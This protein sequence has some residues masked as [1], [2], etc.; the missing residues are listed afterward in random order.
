MRLLECLS[1]ILAVLA[2]V[3]AIDGLA[4]AQDGPPMA[5]HRARYAPALG[6]RQASA[7]PA[8]PD[9]VMTTTTTI[10][11]T[12]SGL[13]ALTNPGLTSLES[14]RPMFCYSAFMDVP[15]CAVSCIK[16]LLV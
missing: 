1:Y 9:A 8:S 7:T 12:V 14:G 11:T 13:P 15:H 2:A 6:G 16:P 3:I 4:L 5:E 10:H